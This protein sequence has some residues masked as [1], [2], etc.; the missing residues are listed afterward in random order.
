MLRSFVVAA[1]VLAASPALAGPAT[2]PTST[3]EAR[4]LAA[5]QPR[6]RPSAQV[7]PVTATSTDEAR[8]LAAQGVRLPTAARV[9]PAI[10]STDEARAA[11]AGLVVVAAPETQPAQVACGKSCACPRG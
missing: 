11:A 1:A 4:A 2:V 7:L 9:V 5:S 6:S 10:S 8:T 3:D